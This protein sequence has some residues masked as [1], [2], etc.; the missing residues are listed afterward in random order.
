MFDLE[1]VRPSVDEIKQHGPSLN[2]I[3][4]LTQQAF[5]ICFPDQAQTAT[6]KL[7]QVLDLIAHYYGFNS[8]GALKVY[9][10]SDTSAILP[11][12]DTQS[13]T[14][15]KIATIYDL[16]VDHQLTDAYYNTLIR[17]VD[18]STL[19]NSINILIDNY[20]PNSLLSMR[21]LVI[22]PWDPCLKVLI[23]NPQSKFDG[24]DVYHFSE[25]DRL[26]RVNILNNMLPRT[27]MAVEE[28]KKFFI[29]PFS[30]FFGG[31]I[32]KQQFINEIAEFFDN[33]AIGS[34]LINA[35]GIMPVPIDSPMFQLMS[36]S[37]TE[38]GNVYAFDDSDRI[39]AMNIEFKIKPRLQ[40]LI[41]TYSPA[42]ACPKLKI[43][44]DH[45]AQFKIEAIEHAVSLEK[46][47]QYSA[48]HIL[49]DMIKFLPS[50]NAYLSQPLAA[51][52]QAEPADS[53]SNL[54]WREF[55]IKY[56]QHM[57]E[58][59]IQKANK[60]IVGQRAT[61]KR[62][63]FDD[64]GML[65][66]NFPKPV[67][68]HDPAQK[69][70]AKVSSTM[71]NYEFSLFMNEMVFWQKLKTSQN[72]FMAQLPF[73]L[74]QNYMIHLFTRPRSNT[75]PST[76]IELATLNIEPIKIGINTESS[77]P[78]YL[79]MGKKDMHCISGPSS[80][81][82]K[83]LKDVVDNRLK[84]MFGLCFIDGSKDK[85]MLKHIQATLTKL[86]RLHDLIV[87]DHSLDFNYVDGLTTNK[88]VYIDLTEITDRESA[89]QNLTSFCSNLRGTIFNNS[90]LPEL[91]L[92]PFTLITHCC[93]DY[94]Q[95]D[96]WGNLHGATFG[97]NT[98][99]LNILHFCESI[100]N[101]DISIP[102]NCN[103]KIFFDTTDGGLAEQLKFMGFDSEELV[104][105]FSKLG[106]NE[107]IFNGPKVHDIAIVKYKS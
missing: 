98:M 26:I 58:L 91:K 78:V 99:Q 90:Q 76:P 92:T 21:Y 64:N 2:N 69:H 93:D 5:N 68:F 24:K 77:L 102:S 22:E 62:I 84:N 1:I 25:I 42:K 52:Y 72:E 46:S 94:L 51:W 67:Q 15:H 8:F 34:G 85:K 10:S 88:V 20:S 100:L 87:T 105:K 11:I 19:P 55:T 49:T 29:A 32:T 44:F 47:E 39:A 89:I 45:F 14:L 107:F 82:Q 18:Y 16:P 80:V 83:L 43:E 17:Y 27:K 38:V 9:L 70:L 104:L 59:M 6:A 65:M 97:I 7:G 23:K 13:K 31:Q 4:I 106:K 66:F 57:T 63:Y 81:Y 74:M 71:S 86:N 40:S 30:D 3:F 33:K 53:E 36:K 56:A 60:Y 95:S 96:H 35:M 48:R 103:N 79:P 101:L 61:L 41:S 37:G 12:K 73:R 28:N 54:A 50:L 75:A